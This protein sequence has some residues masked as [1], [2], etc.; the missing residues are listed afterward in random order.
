M[1]LTSEGKKT[2]T[3]KEK[4]TRCACGQQPVLVRANGKNMAA[5]PNL[6]VC[7]LRSGWFGKEQDAIKNWNTLQEQKKAQ[8]EQAQQKA[9]GKGGGGLCW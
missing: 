2:P 6:L 8:E 3:P 4:P 9:Q 5:C 7:G 1:E